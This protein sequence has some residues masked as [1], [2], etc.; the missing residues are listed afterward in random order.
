MGLCNFFPGR[1]GHLVEG[2]TYARMCSHL[3]ITER[4][5]DLHGREINVGGGGVGVEEKKSL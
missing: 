5:L 3:E 2:E 1:L 4:M